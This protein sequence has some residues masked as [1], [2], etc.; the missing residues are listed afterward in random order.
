M[1]RLAIVVLTAACTKS[2]AA[3]P[4]KSVADSV[5]DT[6]GIVTSGNTVDVLSAADLARAA[7]AL[8]HGGSTGRTLRGNEQLKYVESRRVANGTPEIHDRWTDV[9]FVQSGRATLLSGGRVSGSHAESDGER[10]GGVIQGGTSR[11][12]G[13]GDFVM[14]PAGVPHQYLIAAGDSLRYLTIKV[15]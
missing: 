1:R 4:R 13:A 10:R 11:V 2:G 14:I 15:R 3:N 12:I 9:T 6:T 8:A 7:D 5:A